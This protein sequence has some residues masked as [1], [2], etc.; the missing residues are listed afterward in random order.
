MFNTSQ[1]RDCQQ[2]LKHSISSR[3]S[4]NEIIANSNLMHL[5]R[6]SLDV[7]R[8]SLCYFRKE[9]SWP[10]HYTAEC[11]LLWTGCFKP[12][13]SHCTPLS[14]GTLFVRC[15]LLFL[16][17]QIRYYALWTGAYD[18]T[19]R[20]L[21]QH[22]LALDERPFQFHSREEKKG[23][24]ARQQAAPILQSRVGR[25]IFDNTS[26]CKHFTKDRV[27]VFGDIMKCAPGLHCSHQKVEKA[28]L[29]LSRQ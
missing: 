29:L 28:R 20:S 26:R 5:P 7:W 19:G 4:K 18:K 10:K 9:V 22:N 24:I 2:D 8:K 11:I 1:L 14:A 6:L 23:A 17:P 27:W 3:G 25:S 13:M 12:V 21:H 16:A 15:S